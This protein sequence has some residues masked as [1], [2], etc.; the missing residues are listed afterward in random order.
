MRQ[1]NGGANFHQSFIVTMGLSCIL[2]D[3]RQGNGQQTT[4]GLALA[5]IVYLA[6][7]TIEPAQ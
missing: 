6:L 7:T 5:C 1:Q 2:F 3:T 4:D